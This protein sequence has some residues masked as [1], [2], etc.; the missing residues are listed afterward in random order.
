MIVDLHTHTIFS[1]GVLIPAESARR[2][3]VAEY[4]GIAMTDHAD[5]SNWERCVKS[6]Q[7]FKESYNAADGDFKVLAGV[8]ITHVRPALIADLTRLCRSAGADIVLVHGE[9]ICEPVETGTN[10]AAIEA[11]VDILAHPGLIS[12]EDAKLAAERG[13]FLEI[14]SRKSHCVANGHV[15]KTAKLAG[16]KLVIDNDFHAPGDYVGEQQAMK[17]LMGAGL[18]HK[19]AL[20][21]IQNGIGLFTKKL[22]K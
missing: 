21:A 2:A 14:T 16:A 22:N 9:T 5:H 13:V 3:K 15:A 20:E 7:E 1:D 6:A 18:T 12:L 17:I 10:R 4:S 19:E 11:G 8:E